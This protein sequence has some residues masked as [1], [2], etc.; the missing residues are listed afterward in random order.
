MAEDEEELLTISEAAAKIRVSEETIKRWIRFDQI[1]YKMVGPYQMKRVK[2]SDILK[3]P[4][5]GA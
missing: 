3:E 5:K 1:P 2:L 4:V